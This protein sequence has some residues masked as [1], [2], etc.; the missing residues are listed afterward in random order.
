LVVRYAA[1][2][3]ARFCDECEDA[4]EEQAKT[5]ERKGTRR[6][7]RKATRGR[8]EREGGR[9]TLGQQAKLIEPPSIKTHV[10]LHGRDTVVDAHGDLLGDPEW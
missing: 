8:E 3:A 4:I 6:G 1:V 5:S 10:E 2:S 9:G 7:A